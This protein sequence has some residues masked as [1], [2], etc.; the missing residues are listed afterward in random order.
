MAVKKTELYNSLWSSCDKLHGSMDAFQSKDYV[1]KLLFMKYGFDK[2]AGDL[3]GMI[4]VS[5]GG[6]FRDRVAKLITGRTRR[7]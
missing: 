5:E 1:L 7:V 2:Y 3:S 6:S 4:V